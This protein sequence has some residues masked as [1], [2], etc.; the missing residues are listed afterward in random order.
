M[1]YGTPYKGSKNAIALWVVAYLPSATH[2]YDLFAGGCAVTHCAMLEGRW[3]DITIND[4]DDGPKLFLDAI[5]GKYKNET[6]WIS[7]EDFYRLKD[8]NPYIRYCWSFGNNGSDYLYSR[9]IEPWKKALHY[10][11]VFHDTSLLKA[12]GI[13]SDGSRKDIKKHYA[14]YCRKTGLSCSQEGMQGHKA[15]ECLQRLQSLEH[16][17]DK[18]WR[19]RLSRLD[20]QEVP[21]L[22]DSVIYCDIPYQG[23]NPYSEAFDH[24]RFFNWCEQ[25]K[26]LVVISEYAMPEDRFLCIAEKE[27]RCT[28]SASNKS[29]RTIEKLFI[30]VHQKALFEKM[31]EAT[32][33]DR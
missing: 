12:M 26:E 20:Y 22:P 18:S 10:A 31:W 9:D 15:L 27:K 30:P 16:L 25:Q 19:L 14:E 13:D 3:Q 1:R 4:I 24:E 5:H 17:Q 6:R 8:S 7:R 32:P 23:K 29:K 28:Y 11:R 2:L 21:I 33:V